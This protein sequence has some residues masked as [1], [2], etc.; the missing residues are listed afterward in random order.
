MDFSF[1]KGKRVFVTGHTGFKGSWLCKTLS[2]FGADVTGYALAPDTEPNLFM[3]ADIAGGIDSHSGDIR[4]FDRLKACFD[5][6][7]PE[8]VFHLAAQPLVRKSYEQPLMTFETNVQGTVNLLECIRLSDC[9]RSFVNVT[10]DKVY[11]NADDDRCFIEDDK[12]CGFDPYSNSKSC[13]ELVT[14]SYD[15][16]FF[17]DKGVRVSTARAGNVIGGGDFAAD[18]IVPDCVR[19]AQS[20][21]EIIVRNPYST[22]PFQFVLEPLLVYMLIAEKQYGDA[23]FAGS[24]NVGP[25]LSDCITTGELADLFCAAWGEGLSW[26]N[27]S[28]GGPHEAKFLRLDCT[29]VQNTFGW[30]PKWNI[31]QAIEA[32]VEFS[33]AV[34]GENAG[35]VM[36]RQIRRFFE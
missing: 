31:G 36:D 13:S 12:L 28:A 25:A 16:S 29:K 22:R 27:V 3:M 33:K 21:T 6:A 20:G 11:M 2:L 24:Y 30:Q 8:I 18:R 23:R 32:V 26:K 17:K 4:D 1:Y 34:R 19:A 7:R 5:A 35:E 10:T 9:V 15:Q 14:Y